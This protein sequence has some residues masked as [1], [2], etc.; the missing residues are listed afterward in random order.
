MQSKNSAKPFAEKHLLLV[1][2]V[3]DSIT[4]EVQVTQLVQDR[5]SAVLSD[6]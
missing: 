3:G 1:E 4:N 2:E 6:E 5:I